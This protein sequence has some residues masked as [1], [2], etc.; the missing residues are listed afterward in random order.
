MAEEKKERKIVS[1]S[2]GEEVGKKTAAAATKAVKKAEEAPKAEKKVTTPS[3][4]PATAAAP[5][6]N[7]KGLRIAAVILWVLAIACEIIDL[8]ILFGKIEVNMKNPLILVI[9]LIVL[10]LIFVIVGSQLWKKANHI[11]PASKK[12]KLKFWLW[13]NLGLIVAIVAFLPLIIL[14]LTN[15]DKL[16]AQTRKIALIAA[17]AALVIGGLCSV[18]YNPIS[19]EEKEAAQQELVDYSKVYW[20]Q[21]GKVYHLDDDCYHI[22]N[23]DL[24]M[25]E[26]NAEST[27]IAQAIASGKTRL[28]SSC[29]KRH[30]IDTSNLLTQ[31]YSD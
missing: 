19:S 6:G 5:V 21:F 26:D 7:A 27:A 2:T 8:L 1:A 25:G 16:D 10:D 17:C 11:D 18:D 22:S 20:T 9:G 29:A 31:D 15:K 28:C 30:N 14:L 24:I 13:N 3:G 12:N 4:K 23:S